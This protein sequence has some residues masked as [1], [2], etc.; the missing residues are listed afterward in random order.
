MEVGRPT[1]EHGAESFDPRHRPCGERRWPAVP[2]RGG[3]NRVAVDQTLRGDPI[4]GVAVRPNPEHEGP[5]VAPEDVRHDLLEVRAL[6]VDL[7][8]EA[9]DAR[10]RVCFLAEPMPEAARMLGR[11]RVA[12]AID[13]VAE[14]PVKPLDRARDP[15]AVVKLAEGVGPTG[16][17]AI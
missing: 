14:A 13:P 3:R 1:T 6:Q 5:P 16:G 10:A 17:L 9:R 7:V 11:E 4:L 8:P 15:D 12:E 2:V